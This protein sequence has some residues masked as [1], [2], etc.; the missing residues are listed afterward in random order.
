MR[1][2]PSKSRLTVQ[3]TK[4]YPRL[5]DQMRAEP[6]ASAL[7]PVTENPVVGNFVR[8][9]DKS[10]VSIAKRPSLLLKGSGRVN[11]MLGPEEDL[12]DA[13]V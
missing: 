8:A 6:T 10:G 2:P 13:L 9:M 11:R 12:S 1:E 7:Q 4:G 5:A 3:P